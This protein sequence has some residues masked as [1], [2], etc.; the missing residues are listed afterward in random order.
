[1]AALF[2]LLHGE[3]DLPFRKVFVADDIDLRNLDLGTF[4]DIDDHV[5]VV[6]AGGVGL[7]LNI[8]VDVIEA[9]VVIIVLDDARGLG[10][11]VVGGD[12][13]ARNVDFVADVVGLA[14][15]DAC[16]REP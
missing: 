5:D 6:L 4:V 14:F 8:D 7:L 12:V 15:L 9:F 13:S 2:R 16:E 10:Q 3:L 1:M 11:E